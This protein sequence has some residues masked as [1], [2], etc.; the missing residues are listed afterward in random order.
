LNFEQIVHCSR[1]SAIKVL[2]LSDIYC[3]N[4]KLIPQLSTKTQKYK[5]NKLALGKKHTNTM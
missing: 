2:F 3:N 4:L 1:N 5:L